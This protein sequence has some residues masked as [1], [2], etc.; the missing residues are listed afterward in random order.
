MLRLGDR[1]LHFESGGDSAA[2]SPQHFLKLR[3][4]LT[5]ATRVG[6]DRDG[7]AEKGLSYV[8]ADSLSLRGRTDARK[9][10]RSLM[11]LQQ[12]DAVQ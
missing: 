2:R 5:V 12:V 11:R 9:P 10:V 7:A 3:S 1:S 4:H 8:H 6:D